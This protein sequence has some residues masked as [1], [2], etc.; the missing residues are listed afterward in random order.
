MRRRRVA[1]AATCL[2]LLAAIGSA[3]ASGAKPNAGSYAG[4]VGLNGHVVWVSGAEAK[5]QLDRARG[6][7]VTWVRE[8]LPWAAVEPSPG[9]FDWARTDALMAAASSAQ[10][11]VLGLLGYSARWS[12]T[13]PSG[14][15]DTR[16]APRDPAEYAR[17]ALEVVKRYG[18]R[19]SFWSSRRDLK[20]QPLTAV[21]LWNEPFGFWAWKPNPDPAAYA[22]LVRAAATAIRSYDPS[23]KILIAANVLQVRTDNTLRNW[24][25]EVLAADPGLR[26]LYDAYSVHPYPYPRT[27]SP[28]DDSGDIRWAYSQ[29]T[30]NHNLDPTKPIWITEVGWSTAPSASDAVSEQTQAAYVKGA[31]QRG[32]EEWGS[33]VE[34]VFIYSMDPDNGPPTYREGYYGLRHAD[35]TSKPAWDAL[36]RLVASGRATPLALNAASL[37]VLFSLHG[38]SQRTTPRWFWRWANWRLGMGAYHSYG[39]ASIRHRPAH[40]PTRIPR[41]AWARLKRGS[42][43]RLEVQG[44]VRLPAGLEAKKGRI[45]VLARAGDAWRA[46][47]EGK[48]AGPRFRIAAH[49]RSWRGLTAV[50]VVFEKDT[51]RAA[52]DLRLAPR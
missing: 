29:V 38:D 30:I 8:E 4:R 18:P 21:E 20:P 42:L 23:I 31:L 33:W 37:R 52:A 15:G 36:T 25:Q 47:G 9:A 16:Y 39:R 6:G 48:T 19:G 45:L 28:T 49:P 35:G 10:M 13:D 17:Y 3:P 51:W 27:K 34:R 22:R 11:N 2:A 46:I 24:M 50:R 26:S 32:L 40:I 1:R 44:V 14:A 43:G 7:G 12:S 5:A 41:W